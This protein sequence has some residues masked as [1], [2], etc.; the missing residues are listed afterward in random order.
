[1]MDVKVEKKQEKTYYAIDVAKF[2][3]AMLVVTLHVVTYAFAN[4]A[5][6]GAPPT[7]ND[8]MIMVGLFPLYYI[9]SSGSPTSGS[10]HCLPFPEVFFPGFAAATASLQK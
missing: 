5:V 3:C 2:V 9:F 10:K 7:G 6:D 1:M 4:M 8:N